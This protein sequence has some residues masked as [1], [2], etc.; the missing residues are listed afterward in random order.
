MRKGVEFF[1][2][3]LN[4]NN[5]YSVR[6]FI[7]EVIAG[8]L[9]RLALFGKS[10]KIWLIEDDQDQVFLG[11]EFLPNFNT[12]ADLLKKAVTKSEIN[13]K[14]CLEEQ[15]QHKFKRELQKSVGNSKYF[16]KFLAACLIFREFD[17]NLEN[18][19][20]VETNDTGVTERKWAKIDHGL[21]FEY[22]RFDQECL[23]SDCLEILNFYLQDRKKCKNQILDNL[24][25]FSLLVIQIGYIAELFNCGV[26]KRSNKFTQSTL[27]QSNSIVYFIAQN[28]LFYIQPKPLN[29]IEF[30]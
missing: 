2:K 5:N 6:S 27:K 18:F 19:G 11:S 24:Y 17:F 3:P 25:Q 12:F 26:G 20:I 1:I 10:P 16:A 13:L 4:V 14:N 30:R 9:Y 23:S 8:P 7:T 21:S 29:W 22:Q 28:V 15:I